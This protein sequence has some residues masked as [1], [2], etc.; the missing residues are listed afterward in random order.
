VSSPNGVSYASSQPEKRIFDNSSFPNLEEGFDEYFSHG[1]EENIRG[2]YIS[3][4]YKVNRVSSEFSEALMNLSDD[5]FVPLLDQT[6]FFVMEDAALFYVNFG[7]LGPSKIYI[8]YANGTVEELFSCMRPIQY[9]RFE[10]TSRNLTICTVSW[11]SSGVISVE[12]YTID[13]FTTKLTK[14]DYVS[15]E[16]NNLDIG[17]FV[18]Y[19]QHYLWFYD[20][21]GITFDTLYREE[22]PGNVERVISTNNSE[23][24][25]VETS[26][27]NILY[28]E[29]G[30][31][32]I[33]SYDLF[34]K[35]RQTIYESNSPIMYWSVVDK[36][37]ILIFT[38]EGI[39]FLRMDGTELDIEESDFRPLPFGCSEYGIYFPNDIER[40]LVFMDW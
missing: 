27:G 35:N 1:N 32:V 3:M 28:C 31:N 8:D 39:L 9:L 16:F 10:P 34:G 23:F 12:Y 17:N 2:Q 29:Q 6:N 33:C 24:G 20:D 18:Y 7:Y 5:Q 36:Y 15:D 19:G 30:G 38:E 37:G 40:S 22:S 21:N 14:T 11:I 26:N 25:Q 4:E 13:I